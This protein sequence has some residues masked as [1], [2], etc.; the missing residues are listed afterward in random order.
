M[1]SFSR[2]RSAMRSAAVSVCCGKYSSAVRMLSS[3]RRSA[4]SG[5]KFLLQFG[6]SGGQQHRVAPRIER[7]LR[8]VILHEK[9]AVG[10]SQLELARLEHFAK[11]VFQQRQQH[12][13]I[14]FGFDRM[15]INIE[16]MS[17]GRTGAVFEHVVPK[18]VL[19]ADDSHVI[20]NDVEN[21][22]QAFLAKRGNH[23]GIIFR[24][25]ELRIQDRL[26]DHVVAVR[27]AGL[28]LEIRRRIEM[29]HAE[30]C[31]IRRNL[32]RVAKRHL[33]GLELQPVRRI[34]PARSFRQGFLDRVD[35][36]I[37]QRCGVHRLGGNLR[38]SNVV[39]SRHSFGPVT[40]TS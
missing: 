37:E 28:R 35:E 4:D 5:A 13:V 34:G 8:I 22:A 36:I 15:P 16:E 20:R 6:E 7:Q 29:A 18:R 11:L 27:A 14:E 40:K 24:A 17:V 3:S 31:Q 33:L 26:I 23:R 38:Q 21:L 25:A 30:L 2:C 32:C 12:F 9:S 19:A 1:T 10:I 39:H